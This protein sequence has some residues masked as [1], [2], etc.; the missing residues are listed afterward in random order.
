MGA[1]PAVVP[2]GL[3]GPRKSWFCIRR[4]LGYR[5]AF[6]S[7]GVMVYC[8]YLSGRTDNALQFH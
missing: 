5:T 1:V 2:G 3:T 6:F 7:G 8:A 4:C